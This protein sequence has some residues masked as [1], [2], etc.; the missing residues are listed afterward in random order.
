MLYYFIVLSYVTQFD[1]LTGLLME[2]GQHLGCGTRTNI[3]AGHLLVLGGQENFEDNEFNNKCADR[4][5]IKVVLKILEQSHKD[6]A[7]VS[8]YVQ[9]I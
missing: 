4:K 9:A 6:I 7:L 8:C 3:Y 1:K 5:G 2:Q